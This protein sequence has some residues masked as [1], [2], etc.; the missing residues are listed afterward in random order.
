[1]TKTLK[2]KIAGGFWENA[3]GLLAWH[4]GKWQLYQGLLINTRFGIHTFGMTR[5]IDLL[6]LDQQ[7][8][9]VIIKENLKPWHLFFWNPHYSRVIEGATGIIKSKAIKVGDRVKLA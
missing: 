3:V 6:I 1:M 5:S 9:V 7:D 2:L 4:S 8:Q